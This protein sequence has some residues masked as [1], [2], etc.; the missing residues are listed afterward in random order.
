MVVE[1][2]YSPA[3][4]SGTENTAEPAAGPQAASASRVD[5]RDVGAPWSWYSLN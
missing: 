2:T 4:V 3:R 1:R 5:S